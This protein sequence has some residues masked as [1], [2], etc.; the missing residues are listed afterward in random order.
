MKGKTHLRPL[1]CALY[2]AAG[3]VVAATPPREA[4]GADADW[5]PLFD[6]RSLAGWR[7]SD[8]DGSF[9]VEDGAIVTRGPRS[10]LFYVGDVEGH[11]FRSFELK[12][13][14]QTE[15]GAN[16]GVYFHTAF[17]ETGWPE[18]GYE[19]QVNNSHEDWRRTGSLYAVEDAKETL[20]RDGEWWEYS[21]RVEGRRIVLAVNGKP[22]VD[23]TEPEGFVR[24]E[25]PGRVLSSGTFALQCHDPKSIVRFRHIRVRPLPDRE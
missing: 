6:G 8:T 7:A 5:R 19:A 10:H 25:Q 17:Q 22:T 23:Y 18:K 13:E 12:L 1:L 2:V 16:S 4:G 20:V 14:V 15:P 3:A 21:I 11:D 9:S 24:E